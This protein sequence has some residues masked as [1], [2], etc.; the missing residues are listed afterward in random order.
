M[1]NFLFGMLMLGATLTLASWMYAVP[2]H[3]TKPRLWISGT[4]M[5]TTSYC[6]GAQPTKAIMDSANTPKKIPFAKL[7]VKAGESNREDA[8]VI[9]KIE[10]DSNGNFSIYLPKGN[11]CLVEEWK[12]KPFKLPANDASKT[13]DPACYRNLYNTADFKLTVAIKSIRNLK[14]TFHRA[15]PNN[16]PCVAFKGPLHP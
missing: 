6:G 14:L 10:A 13:A 5:Q 9:E 3:K 4:I 12:T 7:F 11:Y 2:N 16:Q 8:R 1:K 15:C